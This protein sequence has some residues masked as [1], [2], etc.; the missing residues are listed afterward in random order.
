MPVININW[1]SQLNLRLS[2]LLLALGSS[3]EFNFDT[4]PKSPNH[5]P[6]KKIEKLPQKKPVAAAT[7]FSN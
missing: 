7:H 1:S 4:L 2:A 5:P 3:L 6:Q